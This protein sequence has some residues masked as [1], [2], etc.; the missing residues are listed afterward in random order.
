ML[1]SVQRLGE[2]FQILRTHANHASTRAV[3]VGYEK[4][5]GRQSQWQDQEQD[6]FPPMCAIADQQIAK[7]SDGDHQTPR[8]GR[9]AVPPRSL[10]VSPGIQNVVHSFSRES[11]DRG[12]LRCS[13]GLHSGP[14][15]DLQRSRIRFDLLQLALIVGFIEQ[16]TL[17]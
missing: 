9:D 3:D 4:E 13:G 1:L 15:L 6:D 17:M 16:N 5:R 2:A 8:R 10:S 11:Y 12:G 14:Q 7:D